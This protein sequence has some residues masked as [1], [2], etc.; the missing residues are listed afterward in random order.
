MSLVVQLL[1]TKAEKEGVERISEM[2]QQLYNELQAL[3]VR[4]QTLGQGMKV[5]LGWFEGMSDKLNGLQGLHK[6]IQHQIQSQRE[7]TALALHEA[8]KS[9]LQ[10]VKTLISEKEMT[11]PIPPDNA[12]R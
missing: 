11:I 6:S 8:T 10:H 1:E 2:S 9:T 4:T 3:H 12:F 7:E 5:V